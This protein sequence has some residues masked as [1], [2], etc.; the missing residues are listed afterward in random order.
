MSGNT[1]ERVKLT[2]E[3][4]SNVADVDSKGA[5]KALATYLVDSSGNQ[6]DIFSVDIEGIATSEKQDN[7]NT[8]LSSIDGK[9]DEI[10][11]NTSF[12]DGTGTNSVK[13]LTVASTAYAVPATPPTNPYILVLYNG[14][15]YD[16]YWGFQNTN[17]NGILIAPGGIVTLELGAN[18]SVYCYSATAGAD[19]TYTT[20][21]I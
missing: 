19:I 20:K 18:Q 5:K 14:S 17:A 21:E 12:F 2:N 15:A 1:V 13:D 6:I 9:L 3:S 7:G 8:S 4:G 11:T 16:I 10:S